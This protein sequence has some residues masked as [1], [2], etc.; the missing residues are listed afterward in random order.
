VL[1]PSLLFLRTKIGAGRWADL[2]AGSRAR[3]HACRD[4]SRGARVKISRCRGTLGWSSCFGAWLLG[5]KSQPARAARQPQQSA[6]TVLVWSA[7]QK[8]T[9]HSTSIQ[10]A[11]NPGVCVRLFQGAGPRG[12]LRRGSSTRARRQPARAA[13]RAGERRQQQCKERPWPRRQPRRAA[14]RAGQQRRAAWHA[15]ACAEHKQQLALAQY[16]GKATQGKQSTQGARRNSQLPF[17]LRLYGSCLFCRFPSSVC[18]CGK[19]MV[20]R[21]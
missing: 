6:G 2:G 20:R 15:A 21:R 11:L 14:S 1:F 4:A 3:Q 5:R 8:G 12:E 9:A 16:R 19:S 7:E 10:G 17:L 18:V 13:G